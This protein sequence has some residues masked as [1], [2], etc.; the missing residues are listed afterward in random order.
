MSDALL[1]ATVL[2]P[3]FAAAIATG[4]ARAA[5]PVAFITAFA[6]LVLAA[7]LAWQVAATGTVIHAGGAWGAPLGIDVRADGVAA[8]LL[9][10]A[11]TVGCAVTVYATHYFRRIF[12]HEKDRGVRF[13]WP[14][15]L[16]VWAALNATFIATDIFNLYVCLELLT[17][18]AVALVALDAD[19]PAV[20]AAIRYLLLSIAGSL[21]F[22]AGVAIIY[23]AAGTLSIAGIAAAGLHAPA[24]LALMT[25][26]I[27]VKAALLPFHFW[28]PAAHARAPAP[29]SAVLSGLVVKAAFL[30]ILRLWTE[31]FP[32]ALY[33]RGADLLGG[34]GAAA[35]LW[36][37]VHALRQQR[38]KLIIAWSTAA[39]V[40]YL[41]LVFPL[42]TAAPATA[43]TGSL[44]HL[45][46]HALAKAA[47]FLAAGSMI[48]ALG[49]DSLDAIA[50]L[51][52]KL[53]MTFVTFGLAGLT[54]AGMPPSGG[55]IGKW[56]LLTA[57]L[58]TGQWWWA[59][60]IVAGSLLA[61]GYVVLVLRAAFLEPGA[62]PLRHQPPW[63]LTGPALALAL[64][65]IALGIWAEPPLLLL[66]A[67]APDLVPQ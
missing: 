56:L 42:M 18:P 38:V 14:L 47:L 28:L 35:V 16:L 39:Q 10:T 57:A 55:F 29:A 11:A 30:I 13:F 15:W 22:L 36:G 40:G 31:A 19:R 58:T 7:L 12:P 61:A 20:A 48:K 2:L 26:G 45:L 21:L 51:G 6:V 60:P 59:L 65:S 9:V 34:L 44:Y 43:W 62:Q 54:L 4:S 3:L 46:S 37:S 41:F 53:P 8:L 32:D 24:A 64:L 17:L 52:Q 50:G 66:G 27:A 33:T 1:P 67:T 49:S 5:A 63:Q 25:L 23:A